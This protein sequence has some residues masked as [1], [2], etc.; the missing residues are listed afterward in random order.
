MF[1]ISKTLIKSKLSKGVA[2]M[3]NLAV[4]SMSGF[5]K[6]SAS[7][8][9]ATFSPDQL[10]KNHVPIEKGDQNP[11]YHVTELSNGVTVLTEKTI[12]PGP[13]N[14]SFLMDAGTRDETEEL[15]GA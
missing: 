8:E 6:S 10:L 15:S 1:N 5:N 4:K 11:E 13:V 7:Y 2:N 12:F 3:T 14:I 9:M